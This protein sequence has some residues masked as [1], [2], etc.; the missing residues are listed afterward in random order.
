MATPIETIT[1]DTVSITSDRAL[2]DAVAQATWTL[3]LHADSG[4]FDGTL[5]LMDASASET[6]RAS[7]WEGAKAVRERSDGL[8]DLADILE[9]HELQGWASMVFTE[10]A[11]RGGAAYVQIGLMSD[12][13][14]SDAAMIIEDW[15]TR[16][17][18]EEG[19]SAD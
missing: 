8:Q 1:S 18:H 14:C 4:L 9:D 6:L 13:D 19:P 5:E 17:E 16:Y 3:M 10:A 12:V 15:Q 7:L 2:A 11:S